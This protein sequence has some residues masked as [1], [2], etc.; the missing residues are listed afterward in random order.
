MGGDSDN[1]KFPWKLF[2]RQAMVCSLAWTFYFMFGLVLGTPT[3]TIPQLRANSTTLVSDAMASWISSIVGY[4]GMIW[5]FVLTISAHQFGLRKTISLQATNACVAFA[6]LFF[7]RDA[8]QVLVS[9]VIHGATAASQTSTMLLLLT[10]CT[11]PKY[12]GLFIT[13][14]SASFFWGIWVA[15]AVGIYFPYKYIGLLG[16]LCNVYV[17]IIILVMPESPYWLAKKEKYDI[18]AKSH[19]WLKGAG[20]ESVKELESLIAVQREYKS[21]S[22]P[23]KSLLQ[24]IKIYSSAVCQPE[25]YKPLALTFLMHSMYHMSGKLVFTI[26]SIDIL[27]KITGSQST[28]HIGM[29]VLDGITVLGMYTGCGLTRVLKRRTMLLGATSIATTFLFIISAYLYMIRFGVI[30]ENGYVSVALLMA[31]S[32]A[33]ACGPLIMSS[34]IGGELLPIRFR[35][36]CLCIGAFFT[37]LILGISLKIAP[38]IMKWFGTDGSFL[39]FAITSTILIVIACK[40]LPET[41]DKTLLEIAEHFRKEQ[42][43]QS[44]V[45]SLTKHNVNQRQL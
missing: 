23:K 15:N 8:V 21:C 12:R 38:S 32:L 9:Q 22:K 43:L 13:I 34:S 26:Y 25:T 11:T 45:E 27:K 41:K 4:I 29:L 3:V 18:C 35:S 44:E 30:I 2:L 6:V 31:F 14:K 33:I 19:R 10:E 36:F 37:K 5:V 40:Y 17:F 16:V 28:A 39:F 24:Y 1:N 7:S 42:V 20:D